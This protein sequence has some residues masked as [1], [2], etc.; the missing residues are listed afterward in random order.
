MAVTDWVPIV[1]LQKAALGKPKV[2]LLR[3]LSR[4]DLRRVWYA[5]HPAGY[6]VPSE[7]ARLDMAFSK[8]TKREIAMI[9][10]Y[11]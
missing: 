9:I 5:K 2:H 1:G 11:T 7:R 10:A 4:K 6:A 8:L 3:K